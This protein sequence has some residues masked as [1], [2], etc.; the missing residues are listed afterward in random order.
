MDSVSVLNIS[1]L[2]PRLTISPDLVRVLIRWWVLSK[3][4]RPVI[5]SRICRAL[6][7]NP[8]IQRHPTI[9]IG[10]NLC[11]DRVVVLIRVEEAMHT[12]GIIRQ[13]LIFVLHVFDL[14][15]QGRLGANGAVVRHFV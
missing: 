15:R 13:L 5:V 11:N 1:Q 14:L 10:I 4:R 9:A 7:T 12:W 2:K 6:V 8:S 3:I